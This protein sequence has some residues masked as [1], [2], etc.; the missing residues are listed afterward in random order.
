MMRL[1]FS[2][3][4]WQHDGR[5]SCRSASHGVPTSLEVICCIVLLYMCLANCKTSRFRYPNYK[6]VW[7]TAKQVAVLLGK[8]L[9]FLCSHRFTSPF[10]L[11]CVHP[12]IFDLAKETRPNLYKSD[13]VGRSES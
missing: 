7:L 11:T 12:T 1:S 13:S 4:P 9:V 10:L 3:A 5:G 6:F 8:S 2:V